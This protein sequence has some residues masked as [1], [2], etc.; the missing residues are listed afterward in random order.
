V[1][2]R[3]HVCST[4]CALAIKWPR[5]KDPSRV[6]P[7]QEVHHA[8]AYA[9]KP[10]SYQNILFMANITVRA[11]TETDGEIIL[12][13]MDAN[14][15]WFRTIGST[16]WGPELFSESTNMAAYWRGLAGSG[17]LLGEGT[18]QTFVVEVDEWEDGN[19]GRRVGGF[20]VI[21]K[22]WPRYG[23]SHWQSVREGVDSLA[24]NIVQCPMLMSPR[25]SSIMPRYTQI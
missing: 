19:V 24:S 16:Q 7:L 23:E 3:E 25:Y 6:Q 21:G 9:I 18:K 12:S 8:Y 22:R 20:Y 17:D 14:V 13:I 4:P 5:R 2:I 1:R 11:S 15:L 10:R